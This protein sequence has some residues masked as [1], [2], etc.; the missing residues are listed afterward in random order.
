MTPHEQMKLYDEAGTTYWLE[1]I[2]TITGDFD[3]S[4]S[5][6]VIS[7]SD[8]WIQLS[9]KGKRGF[10]LNLNQVVSFAIVTE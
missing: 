6:E 1:G 2:E 3:F 4:N 5:W 9:W 10:F 8:D 7:H